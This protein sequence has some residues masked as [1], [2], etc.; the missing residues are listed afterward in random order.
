MYLNQWVVHPPEYIEN[1][2]YAHTQLRG[3]GDLDIFQGHN[4][5]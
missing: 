1:T 2:T 3:H 4:K 5:S